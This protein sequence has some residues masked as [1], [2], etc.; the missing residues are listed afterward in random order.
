MK[1][2]TTTNTGTGT[3]FAP[4]PSGDLHVG[5]ARTAL[6]CWAFARGRQGRFVLRIE[7]TDRKRSSGAAALGFLEDLDWLGMSWD[8][9]PELDGSTRGEHGPYFQSQRLELYQK[10]LADLLDRDLAYHA[11]DTAEELDDKRRAARAAKQPYRYDRAGLEVPR[12]ERIARAEAGEPH[13]V[14]FRTP[15][16]PVVITDAV[17]GEATLPEGEVDDFVIRKA[18][19]YP[20]YH[21]AVVVDDALMECTHVLR[22]QEH[23]NNTA[24]HLLLQEALGFPHP[25][26]GHLSLIMNPDGSK[27]SK[28]DKDK[29]VR[30]AVKQAGIEAPP[31]GSIAP[32]VF[33]AWIADKKAQLENTDLVRLAEAL[34]VELPE[35]NV[36]DFRRSGY[37][38]EV[39]CNFLALNGWSPGNDLEKFDN[40]FLAEH[41][42]LSRVQKTPARFDR[43]KLRA[44]NLDAIQSMTPREFR[45]KVHAHGE[46]FHP[47]FLN[48]LTDEQFDMLAEASRERSKTLDELYQGNR[49]LVV[50]DGDLSWPIS[51]GVRKAMLKGEPRGLDLLE[52]LL[53][54]LAGLEAFTGVALEGTITAWADE[55][56]E[57]NLGKIAQPLRIAATGGTVS[58]PVFDTLA[59]LGRESFV[60]RANGCI[61]ALHEHAATMNT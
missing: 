52:Q 26:Y 6:F 11:F 53:P 57:G 17:L 25:V 27:M 43:D 55:H 39:L 38:P 14:R 40:A 8:E 29:A 5:G 44:F 33:N 20:T 9:G 35:I 37:L 24:K 30:A 3:R 19:G 28:R 59:M 22:A 61:R 60:A 1:N 7:D 31:E 16:R 49:W 36:K 34:D 23:F 50:E 47:E 46:Q 51:K 15:D 54:T 10:H 12:D 13:V 56:C 41:F 58:P 48:R 18:D 45:D 42:D 21:F 4:S 32:E 2:Q